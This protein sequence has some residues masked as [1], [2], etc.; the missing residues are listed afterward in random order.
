[1]NC[2]QARQAIPVDLDG[3][4]NSLEEHA[5]REHL[6]GCLACR[7]ILRQHQA[8]HD[9]MARLA[10]LPCDSDEVAATPASPSAGQER[11]AAVPAVRRCRRWRVSVA[12]AAALILFICGWWITAQ[13]RSDVSRHPGAAA[14]SPESQAEAAAGSLVSSQQGRVE[15]DSDPRPVVRVEFGRSADVIALPQPTRNPNITV[16][17]I[18]PAVK[19]AQAPPRSAVEPQPNQEGAQS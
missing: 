19:T 3:E 4:L 10:A 5:L 12:A 9:T 1:M 17:W 13:M 15:A 18:Y 16:F 6:A 8:I 2:S 11:P 7:G 14:H